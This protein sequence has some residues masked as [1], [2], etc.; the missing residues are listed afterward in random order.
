MTR[1]PDPRLARAQPHPAA[2][3]L[4]RPTPCSPGPVR[5]RG[6]L[7]RERGGAPRAASLPWSS[8]AAT[9]RIRATE[10][11]TF[12]GVPFD[13]GGR[14][15]LGSRATPRGRGER[16]RA[17]WIAKRHG[18][19]NVTQ[20]H[21][22]RRGI[23][24]EEMAH[25]AARER[26][27]PELVREEV[28]RG[29]MV[30]PANVK[31]P[32]LEPMRDRRRGDLQDQREHREQ[33]GQLRRRRGARRSSPC[34]CSYGADTV[35]DLSTGG[36]I[37]LI[38]ESILRHSPIPVGTVP[39]YE[40]LAHVKDVED[41][42]PRMLLDIIE[43]QA[44]QGVDYMTIHAGVLRDIVPLAPRRITG[45]VSPRRR[46]HGAVDGRARAGEP[47]LHA[48][49]RRFCEIFK[50]YDVTFSLGDGLRPG[51][52][53]DASD[54][55]QFAELKVLGE[56]TRR[57]W[58]ARRPGDGRGPRPRPARSDPD[59]H[60]EGAG[61]LRRG[62]VLRARPARHGHRARLRPHHERDRRG[63]RRAS[64]AR[65]CSA[66]SRPPSTSASPTWRTSGRGSSPTRSPPTPPTSPATG[67][68]RAI[69]TT[70]CPG[71]ATRS[72]GSASSS[73]RSTP[74]PRARS[75]TRRCRRRRSSRPSS[76]RC[77]GRSSARC[78]IHSHLGDAAPAAPGAGAPP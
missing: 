46:A 31:H 33:R 54:E 27:E 3:A 56:L 7:R 14:G 26:L 4:A 8:G 69:A 13:R 39:I 6:R 59:E 2:L 57:A 34:A 44:A 41:L 73:S 18:T 53:A 74:R 21:H 25:V 67:P 45:I 48:L 19:P 58:A 30:I 76:A 32:E 1:P 23:V 37:P 16:M 49:R 61:A 78:G 28:A 9:R 5:H 75:T 42:T 52:L 20:M 62:A 35:M 43:A 51:C 29:R 72:T 36:D 12:L 60:A 47:A 11:R 24:T 66:T 64:T 71:R 55:A 22:A 40:C 68:A 15:S 63:R 38:R 70:R 50:R 10:K 17:E 77:A 65:R